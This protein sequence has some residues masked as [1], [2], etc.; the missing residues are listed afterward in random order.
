MYFLIRSLPVLHRLETLKIYP[1]KE[2]FN[3][4]R[5]KHNMIWFL[6]T[7]PDPDNDLPEA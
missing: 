1:G 3:P 5:Y 2:F 7:Q 4:A 6:G